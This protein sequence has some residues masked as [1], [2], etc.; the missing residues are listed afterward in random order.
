MRETAQR[1]PGRQEREQH[2]QKEGVRDWRGVRLRGARSRRARSQNKI[3]GPRLR[4][5]HGHDRSSRQGDQQCGKQASKGTPGRADFWGL[6]S[7]AMQWRSQL[8]V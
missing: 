8:R 7:M 5:Q 6:N 4:D 3:G 1:I 2:C